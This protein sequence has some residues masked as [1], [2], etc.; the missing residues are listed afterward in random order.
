M[1]FLW[2]WLPFL[3]VSILAQFTLAPVIVRFTSSHPACPEFEAA[4]IGQLPPD[5]AANLGR[6]VYA[7]NAEG[8]VLVGYFRQLAYMRNVGFYL[9]LMKHPVHADMVYAMEMF[10]NNGIVPVRSA[11]IEFCT[12][13]ADGNEICTNHSKQPSVHKAHPA[14]RVHRFP[15]AQNPHLLYAIHHR[16]CA[17]LAPGVARVPMAEGM[18]LF[19]LSYGTVKDVRKQAEFGY[20]YLDERRNAFRP[21]MKGACI[22]TWRLAWP[23]GALRR[24][25][26]RKKA[27][28]TMLSLGF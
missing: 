9:A 4:G 23:I 2:T 8:F 13:F 11:H 10:A 5:V 20:Y 28:A 18:E 19:Y 6:F 25:R 21:S 15:E 14:M 27:R 26:M 1:D 16:L 22:I 24:S 17:S 12:D 3:L 7:M